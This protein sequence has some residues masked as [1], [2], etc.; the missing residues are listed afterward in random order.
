MFQHRDELLIYSRGGRVPPATRAGPRYPGGL[1]PADLDALTFQATRDRWS[2]RWAGARRLIG[3]LRPARPAPPR[4]G[5]PRPGATRPGAARPGAPRPGAA[6]PG[7]ARSPEMRG[8]IDYESYV[9][10]EFAVG[11]AVEDE[12]WL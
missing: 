9:E 1:S 4:P 6:W 7:P 11:F 10:L 3:A 8:Y 2:R 12:Q 5:A